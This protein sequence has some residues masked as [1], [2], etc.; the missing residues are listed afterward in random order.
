MFGIWPLIEGVFNIAMAIAAVLAMT[1]TLRYLNQKTGNKFDE[2]LS[3]ASPN[4]RLGYFGARIV[5]YAYIFGSIL[6]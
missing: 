3:D 6:S 4:V 1:Y 5:A 2:T